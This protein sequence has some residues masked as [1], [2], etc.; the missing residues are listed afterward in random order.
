MLMNEGAGKVTVILIVARFFLIKSSLSLRCQ[1][2]SSTWICLQSE[3]IRDGLDD[4]LSLR[5]KKQVL[6]LHD[7][8][9]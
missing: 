6:A 5:L 8:L 4:R 7:L 1:K 3:V 2:S 9:E